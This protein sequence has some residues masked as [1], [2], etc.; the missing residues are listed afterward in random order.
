MNTF[1]VTTPTNNLLIPI[2]AFSATDDTAVTGYLITTSSTPPTAGAASW[3]GTAPATYKVLSDGSY[4]LYPWAKDAAGNVSAVFASPRTVVVDTT[5]PTVQ[6]ITRADTNPTSAASVHFTITFSEAVMGVDA[7]DF[8]LMAT[9]ISGAA[10]SGVSGAGS[11]YTVTVNTGSGNGTIRLDVP[12]SASITDLALN[13]LASLPYN[14]GETYTIT[15]TV[16]IFLPLI[17]R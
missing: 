4:T 11:V 6:T 13:P 8:T 9:G 1:T 14:G 7:T 3:T 15:K 16:Y 10:V 5:A 12:A 2:I 17:L